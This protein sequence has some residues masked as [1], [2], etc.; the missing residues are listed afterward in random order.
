MTMPQSIFILMFMLV[1][2]MHVSAHPSHHPHFDTCPTAGEYA[3]IA[4]LCMWCDP[5]VMEWTQKPCPEHF[6][7]KQ[8]T[9]EDMPGC[10]AKN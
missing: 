8:D 3:C 10:V 2:A 6:M 7:C 1:V 9:L 5:H 4:G